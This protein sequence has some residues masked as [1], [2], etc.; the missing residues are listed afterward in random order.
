MLN[1]RISDCNFNKLDNGKSL[2][3]K[4][5]FAFKANKDLIEKN[6]KISY[7]KLYKFV[8]YINSFKKKLLI[9]K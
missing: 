6:Y 7:P 5:W 3:E 8:K 4:S 1:F 2:G 9:S